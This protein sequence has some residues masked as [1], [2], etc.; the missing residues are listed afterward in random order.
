MLDLGLLYI[1]CHVEVLVY[2]SFW[3]DKSYLL[4]I[5]EDKY[6]FWV[7]TMENRLV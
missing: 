1:Y 2:H 7:Q 3:V 4:V 6:D 5:M